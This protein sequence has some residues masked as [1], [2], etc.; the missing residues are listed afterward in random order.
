MN[1]TAIIVAAGS[2]LGVFGAQSAL[3]QWVSFANETA[4]RLQLSSVGIN[5]T[6]EKDMTV[7]DFNND[8][9]TDIVVA[10]KRPFSNPGPRSD[11]LLMNEQGTLV[12]RTQDLATGF[13]ST[14]TD[15]RDVITRDFD[16]DGWLDIVVISTFG[17]QPQYYAN[18]G[19]N[20]AGEWLGF[21][22]QSSTRLPT[23]TVNPIQF[24]AVWAGDLDDNGWE[25]F[26]M[27]NYQGNPAQDVLLM[28]TGNGVFVD[29]SDARLGNLRNS[30]FGTGVE[31]ADLDGDGDL[32]IVKTST[33]FGTAPWNT[34]G[35]FPMFNDGT[36]HFSWNGMQLGGGDPYMF[37]IAD[38]NGDDAPDIYAVRDGQ[39][40]MYLRTGAVPDTSLSYSSNTVSSGRTNGF[41]GNVKHTDIDG[42]GDLD[43]GVAPIDVDIQNCGQGREFALLR[44]P[45]NGLLTDPFT[46][47][48]GIHTEAHDFDFIDINRDGCMDIFMGLCTGWRV[49]IQDTEGCGI[50]PA[51]ADFNGDGVVN[52]ADLAVVLSNWGPNAGPADLTGDGVVNGSDL[53]ALLASWG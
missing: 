53:A 20:T 5:D 35:I 7:G 8:G 3:A 4:T 37:N 15:A 2:A 21:E 26:Y 50:A 16:K 24:C 51:P 30:A 25:D 41:G 44:N 17:V 39:D 45:G 32:D 12:D 6:E 22:N 31:F 34:N 29:E 23:V 48:Q 46:T 14:L 9:W 49:F 42:D 36:G 1:R 10:R 33:L 19:R 52:G 43:A 27:V 18:L 13:I 47:D 40:T 38:F 11:V 28:N